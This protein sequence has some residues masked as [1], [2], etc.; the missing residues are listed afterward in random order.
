MVT[1]R[2]GWIGALVVLLALSGCRPVQ[3]P[4]VLTATPPAEQTPTPTAEETPAADETPA[5]EETPA[6]NE[7]PAADETPVGDASTGGGVAAAGAAGALNEVTVTAVEYSFDAPES[8]P[9]GWTRFTLQNEGE[10]DHDFQLFKLETGRTLDDMMAALEAEG[11][12]EWA[13]AYGS[14]TAAA[15]ESSWFAADLTPGSYAYLSF[16]SSEGGPPDAAQGMMGM[17]TVTETGAAG[18]GDAGT[19]PIDQDV[20]IDLVDYQFVIDGEFA[21]GEQVLRVRNSGTELHEVIFFKLREGKTMADFMA[22]LEREMSGEMVPEEEIPGEFAGG[23]FLSPGRESYAPQV[24]TPGDYV[25]ICFIP[26]PEHD[27]QTHA[28]LGMIRQVTID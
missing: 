3:D 11:P 20:A 7:T 13:E 26:S 18:T 1:F 8:V 5:A 15:G 28:E 10:A 12:P 23:L 4:A 6:A 25:L 19:F 27:M 24:F 16:G 17:L 9:S 14:A 21:A 2:I 22:T